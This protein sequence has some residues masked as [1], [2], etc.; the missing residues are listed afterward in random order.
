MRRRLAFGLVRD[1]QPIHHLSRVA[2]WSLT[3]QHS[4]SRFRG[5][6]HMDYVEIAQVMRSCGF[7]I[8]GPQAFDTVECRNRIN[9]TGT[10]ENW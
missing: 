9:A 5:I 4:V 6:E 10:F 2:Q 3:L 1:L 7:G 8:V